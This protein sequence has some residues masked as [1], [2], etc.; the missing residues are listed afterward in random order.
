MGTD[1]QMF[2]FSFLNVVERSFFLMD[3]KLKLE[4]L[5]VVKYSFFNHDR[6]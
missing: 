2:D 6:K 5:K 1:F 4:N 3:F